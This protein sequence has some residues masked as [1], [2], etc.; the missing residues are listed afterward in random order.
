M[1]GDG[2]VNAQPL[3]ALL[4]EPMQESAERAAHRLRIEAMLRREQAALPG[5]RLEELAGRFNLDALETDILA[6]LWTAAFDPALRTKLAERDAY[7]DQLTVR[8]VAGV[9]NHPLRVHLRSES[10]L[11]L[12]RMVEERALPDGSAAL[13]LNPAILAWLEGEDEI[14]RALAGRAYLLPASPELPSW[15]LDAVERDLREG[16]H[17]GQRWRVQVLGPDDL[18]ARWFAAALGRRLGLPVLAIPAGALAGEADAAVYLH[19]QAFL[20]TSIPC[21]VMEDAP[22][23]QPPGVLPYAVQIVHG[24]QLLAQPVAGVRDLSVELPMPNA[25]ERVGLWRSLWP[26]ALAWAPTEF[27]D[28]VLCHEA[29]ISEIAAAAATSPQ[30]PRDAVRA[31]RERLRNDLGLLARRSESAFAW[32]DLVLPEPIHARLQEIA[33]EA[34]ERARVWAEPAAARLFPYGR[35][36]VALFAGP[37]G[38]GK[39]MAAQVIAADLGV[40]IYTVDLSAVISKWVGETAQHIQQLLSSRTAQRSVLFF[41]EADALFAKR[42]EEVRD[43]QD[44]FANMDTSHLM[45]A[46]EAYPGIVILASNLKGNVD[47]AFLRRIRH[48]VDFPKPDRP[49]RAQIW[50]RA[51]DALFPALQ[52]EAVAAD[53]PRLAGAEATGA[54]IKNAALSALFAARHAQV[55]PT[56]KLFGEMLAREL[57]KEGAGLSQRDLDT[58]LETPS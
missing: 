53:L 52:I 15:P 43:A 55:L 30:S 18:A 12:W 7:P 25:E 24:P 23:A 8:C 54:Q 56:A 22:L 26:Q 49:A 10:P 11:R 34:R 2:A 42:V 39:T 21:I 41:D 1:V 40:D 35:A 4:P 50:R 46:L 5:G 37:P 13:T 16:L 51:L 31:L 28:L 48:V 45:T 17:A 44:R 58:L 20:S 6:A 9:F 57:A 36:L 32:D 38:T 3:E 27:V 33:F 19:R 14:D 29:G 47:T